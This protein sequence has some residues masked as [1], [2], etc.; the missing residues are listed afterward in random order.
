MV[1]YEIGGI[2]ADD[3]RKLGTTLAPGSYRVLYTG[4]IVL[5]CGRGPA[6]LK[7]LT[8]KTPEFEQAQ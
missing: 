7:I 2:N 6:D 1:N 8:P 3:Y 5:N 4:H